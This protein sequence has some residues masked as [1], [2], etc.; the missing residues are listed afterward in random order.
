[1]KK[2]ISKEILVLL[3]GAAAVVLMIYLMA[4]FYGGVMERAGVHTTELS[5]EYEYQYEMIVDSRNTTFW[6]SVYEKARLE[7]MEHGAVLEL[8]GADWGQDYDKADFMDMSIASQVDGIILEYNGEKNLDKKINEAVVKGIPVVIIVNDAPKSLRQAFVGINDYQLGQAYGAQVTTLL[9]ENTRR[10]LVLLNREE[11]LN[12]NQIY[13]QI[14]SAV[15]EKVGESGKVEIQAQNLISKSQFDVEEAVR[16]I[17]QSLEGPSEILVCL[18]EVTAECAYQAMIDYNMVGKV[19]I[20][21]YYTSDTIMEAVKKGLIP[22]TCSMD[23]A[24]IG[25]YSIQA[26]T[27]YW[28]EGRTNSYYNVDLNFIT[29]D[30]WKQWQEGEE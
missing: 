19:K 18:D 20:V 7:A 30:N 14:N 25:T 21:G 24:Q 27:D 11:E 2:K 26:L 3:L 23:T 15:T 10:V 17:F 8:K 13:G 22:I 29:Q 9:D 4:N 28:E 16:N 6:Q 5:Q 1:M 12:Q